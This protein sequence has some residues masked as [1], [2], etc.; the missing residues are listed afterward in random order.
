MLKLLLAL[1]GSAHIIS[2]PLEKKK[3]DGIPRQH[4]F[5]DKSIL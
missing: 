3:V 2:L 1:F 5:I 4:M